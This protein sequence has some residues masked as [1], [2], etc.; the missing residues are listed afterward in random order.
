[1]DKTIDILVPTYKRPHDLQRLATNLEQTTYGKFVLYFGLEPDDKE[2]QAAADFTSHKVVVNK[3]EP[4][5]S[6]T[7]QTLYEFSNNPFI[8]HANDDFEFMEGWDEKPIAMF[9]RKDLMVVG[10]PQTEGDFHGSA[11]SMF[12]RKYIE[13][14]SGVIDMP[15]RVFFPY[16]HHYVDT[17]FTRTAQFR[18][19]WAMCDSRGINHM[20]PG[21]TGK[22]PDETNKKNDATSEI[23]RQIFES[24]QHLWGGI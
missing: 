18:N 15:N 5:Y 19:V 11:I 4:G 21:F 16:P 2:G 12:R 23:A 22:P 14:M 13:E 10:M 7:I 20:H 3:Y 8:I 17:E 1:M 9:D 6:N 24:R